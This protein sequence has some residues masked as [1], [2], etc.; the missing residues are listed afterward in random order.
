MKAARGARTL[1]DVAVELRGFDA[2]AVHVS[3]TTIQRLESGATGETSAATVLV[4]AL[5][6][7]YG[8]ELVELSAY[9]AGERDRTLRVLAPSGWVA[10]DLNPEPAG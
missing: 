2:E 3:P 1:F 9:H 7:I 10:R 8:V 4:A 6:A 5:A